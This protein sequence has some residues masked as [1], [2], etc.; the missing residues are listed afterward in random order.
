MKSWVFALALVAPALW[1]MARRRHLR[2]RFGPEYERT[3][4]HT[5]NH[6]RCHTALGGHLPI[7]RV[8]NAAGQYT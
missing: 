3:V 7:S 6:H 2:E 8:N 1:T 5:Y 4:L